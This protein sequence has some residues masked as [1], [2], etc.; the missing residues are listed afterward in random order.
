MPPTAKRTAPPPTM[1]VTIPTN[2]NGI[3]ARIKPV[4]NDASGMLMSLYG[5]PKSGKTRFACTFPKPLLIIGTED[6]TKSIMGI[7][8]VDFVKLNK[9][10]EVMELVNSGFLTNYKTVV[11]DNG[12]GFRDMRIKEILKLDTLP[13]QK[14]WG[15]AS[16]SEWGECSMSIKKMLAPL[17]QLG[18]DRVLNV[19]CIAQEADLNS[20]DEGGSSQ[21][22]DLIKPRI[23][24]AL[25]KSV[26]DWLNAE[27]DYIGQL[28]VRHGTRESQV[29]AIKDGP[30]STI[31]ER[32]GMI[33][34]SLRVKPNGVHDC[35]FRVS[36]GVK[37]KDE[38]LNLTDT[39]DGYERLVKL[40]LGEGGG[41]T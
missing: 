4:V 18:K 14:G 11:L 16:R 1:S 31:K 19:V 13:V 26:C 15:F 39:T 40:I 7:A 5:P 6:G 23:G 29:Q 10:E 24:P 27:C 33:E 2:A 34:Y 28:V 3:L 36:L 9:C 38:F 32:T 25:G 35:G 20:R 17:L 8:G 37:I 12:T 22:N 21:D 41:E 30:V